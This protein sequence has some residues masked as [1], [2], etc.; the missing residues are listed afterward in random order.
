[1]PANFS[2]REAA[3]FYSVAM[4]HY[5]MLKESPDSPEILEIR[6]EDFLKDKIGG[7]K[8]I[9]SFCG[10]EG[11]EEALPAFEA[12]LAKHPEAPHD[13]NNIHPDT[14]GFVNQYASEYVTRFGYPQRTC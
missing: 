5:F 1:L 11:F 10:M 4:K 13:T 9:Y 2:R 7:L 12:Y 6:L 14:I 8:E 3:W